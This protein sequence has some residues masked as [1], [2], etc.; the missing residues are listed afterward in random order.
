MNFLIVIADQLSPRALP[1]YGNRVVK[2]PTISALAASGVVFEHAYCTFPLCAPSRASF[3]TGV[4]ASATGVFDNGAELPASLPTLA[5]RLRARGY[6]TGLAGK[7]HFIGPDQ[8]H[9]FER[10]LT[11]DIYP[12]GMLWIPDWTAPLSEHLPWYHDMTSVFGAGVA[13]S[14]LQLAYD[15]E[16]AA[17][18]IR[19]IGEFAGA[20]DGRPFLLVAS[21]SQPHDPW[22]V[23]AEYWNRYEGVEIDEPRVGPIPD[24]EV[25][26][27]T[28]RV[29]EMCGALGLEVPRDVLLRARRGH[30][31]S[32]S[33]VDDK[34]ASLLAALEAAGVRDDTVVVFM[35]DHGEMLGERGDWYK[36]LFFE[37]SAGVPF[38]VN[39]P[40]S[41]A[42]SRVGGNVSLLDLAP[43][44]VEL[45]GGDVA[46]LQGRSL[47]GQ[48]RG[49]TTG[50]DAVFGE[51][52]A[53]G[54]VAPAVMVKR[55]PLKYVASS[56]DPEMLFDLDDDPDELRNVARETKY[57]EKVDAFRQEVARRW[58]LDALQRDILES[59][60]RRR[61]VAG[62]LRVGDAPRWDLGD[63]D[64]PYI[65]SE[66]FWAP[67]ERFR[68]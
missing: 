40:H 52:L 68:K 7:M 1:P 58:Q 3:M 53:E 44:L 63:P 62:A 64:G 57:R 14:S 26:P 56:V 15:E 11:P 18:S 22:E 10:R 67:F 39:A 17:S 12:A 33:Y 48:L 6:R 59:Q 55:G 51:Y 28:R 60:R 47:V 2:A 66:D 43:T 31:A 35:A 36:M 19:A 13:E 41:F 4:L 8:L 49:S 34:V 61:L 23:P 24:D 46:G 21:F 29:R 5:H 30:Y 20:G 27:H 45:A 38:I 50:D 32:I 42:P 65:R 16:V 25:D 54:A 37:P 9:G